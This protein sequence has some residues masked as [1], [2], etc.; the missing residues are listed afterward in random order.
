M[1]GKRKCATQIK[2]DSHSDSDVSDSEFQ[3][4]FEIAAS[5][6]LITA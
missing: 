2:S 3:V 6:L 4:N 5:I 1:T